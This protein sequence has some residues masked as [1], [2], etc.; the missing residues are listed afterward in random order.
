MNQ[1]RP[2]QLPRQRLAKT[3]MNGRLWPRPSV[4]WISA[5]VKTAA[6]EAVNTDGRRALRTVGDLVEQRRDLNDTFRDALNQ[7]L[8]LIGRLE[9]REVQTST[10]LDSL[11]ERFDKL[12][13]AVADLARQVQALRSSTPPPERNEIFNEG[14]V[15]ALVNGQR[16]TNRALATS[17]DEIRELL[18]VSINDAARERENATPQAFDVR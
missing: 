5:L 16:E 9:R 6:D 4:D 3:G 14:L 15:E 11:I 7:C 2:K 17:L 1:L 12:D 18:Q 10:V 13:Q 8:G